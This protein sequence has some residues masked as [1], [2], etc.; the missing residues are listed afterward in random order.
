[1]TIGAEILDQLDIISNDYNI[2]HTHICVL[3]YIPSQPFFEEY[4]TVVG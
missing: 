1:M 3:I 4:I 2:F